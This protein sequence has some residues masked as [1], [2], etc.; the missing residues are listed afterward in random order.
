MGIH[1]EVG[2]L[3]LGKLAAGVDGHVA[4]RAQAGQ[5]A[6]VEYILDRARMRHDEYL[7]PPGHRP[8][9]LS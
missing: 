8:A 2:E 6:G 7:E 3:P 4:Q 5:I 9:S 1:G